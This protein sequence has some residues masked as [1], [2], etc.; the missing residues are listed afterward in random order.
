M[1]QFKE[2]GFRKWNYESIENMFYVWVP[3]LQIVNYSSFWLNKM[4]EHSSLD[5]ADI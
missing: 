4:S 5:I 2:T 1:L 3:N